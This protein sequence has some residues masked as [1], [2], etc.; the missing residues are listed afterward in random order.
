M[1]H[2]EWTNCPLVKDGDT[3]TM[4]AAPVDCQ[5]CKDKLAHPVTTDESRQTR[6]DVEE[7]K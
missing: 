2:S 5:Y 7:T 1:T 4:L 3:V 6:Q